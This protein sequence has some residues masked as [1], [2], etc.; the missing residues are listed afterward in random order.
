MVV[1]WLPTPVVVVFAVACVFV[2]GQMSR[3]SFDFL[4][5]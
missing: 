1:K 2:A 5:I 3:H 4:L